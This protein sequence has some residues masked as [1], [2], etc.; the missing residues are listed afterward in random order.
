MIFNMLLTIVLVAALSF[1]LIARYL[2]L[3]PLVGFLLAGFAIPFIPNAETI[4]F[5]LIADT[6]ITLLLFT[7][8][9]K[10][11]WN[12]LIKRHVWA[13]AG[14]QMLSMQIFFFCSLCLLSYFLADSLGSFDAKLIATIAFALSFSS[15]VFAV[16]VLENQGELDSFH[17]KT[18]IAILIV[19]DIFAVF[20]LVAISGR[21]PEWYAPVVL[22]LFF[23]RPFF[24]WILKHSGH[25]ELLLVA[26]LGFS[27]TGFFVFE[28]V[29][30]KGDLGA[31]FMGLV[32]STLPKSKEVS[33]H[34]LNIK[35]LLLVGF[36]LSIGQSGLP[37]MQGLFLA[38]L[39]AVLIL[40]KPFCYFLLFRFFRL[41]ARSAWLSAFTLG[42]YSEFGLIVM[43]Y[44]ARDG[45]LSNEW[46]SIF[47]IAFALSLII[48]SQNLKLAKRA[49][50]TQRKKIERRFGYASREHKI[51]SEQK[52]INI[53]DADVLICGMGRLGTGAYDYLE[54]HHSK[55]LLGIEQRRK[56]VFSHTEKGNNVMQADANDLDFW[57]RVPLH[58]IKEILLALT[59]HNEQM[60]LVYLLRE[61]GFKGAIAAT[62]KFPDEVV[63]LKEQGVTAFNYYEEAGAGF[64]EHVMNS[65]DFIKG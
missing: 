36:F 8:G 35:D 41:R 15:T 49:W 3:P 59:N 10:L 4:N 12:T 48:G 20:W 29:G 2:K 18:T 34:L 54:K 46:L 65:E 21:I 23:L 1:G 50:L 7:I 19:Q 32:L 53:G 51:L 37:S 42:N 62:A 6:G 38:C 31:L 33:K 16:K 63:E 27:A 11:E 14:V 60:A 56:Q 43:A 22:C 40:V 47:A 45:I 57:E 52:A 28:S 58:Q 39:L 9:L 61:A 13:F 44:A 25:G 55:K 26:A 24:S 17:G 64:A 5:N 30:L